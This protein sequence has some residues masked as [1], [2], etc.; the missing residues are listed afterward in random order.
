MGNLGRTQRR[1]AKAFVALPKA[2]QGRVD[3]RGRLIRE[4][5]EAR[6]QARRDRRSQTALMAAR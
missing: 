4:Q 2:I 5:I 3:E 1:T 6:K